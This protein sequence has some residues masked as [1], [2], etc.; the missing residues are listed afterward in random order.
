MIYIYI[1]NISDTVFSIEKKS[2]LQNYYF[3]ETSLAAQ[4]FKTLPSKAE[5]V[6]LIGELRPHVLCGRKSKT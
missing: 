1:T 6:G 3:H 5:A 2:I 4:W